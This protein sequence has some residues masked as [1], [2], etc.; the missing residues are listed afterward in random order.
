MNQPP[1]TLPGKPSS[2]MLRTFRPSHF[3]DIEVN[4]GPDPAATMP[5]HFHEEIQITAY[6]GGV[7]DYRIG[8]R[9]LWAT[10]G[11]VVV[12]PSGEPHT[13]HTRE[14]DASTIHLMLVSP[15]RFS[16]AASELGGDVRELEPMAG[17]VPLCWR[18]GELVSAFSVGSPL[19][20]E[21]LFLDLVRDLL[22][23]SSRPI[24]NRAEP[25]AIRLAIEYLRERYAHPVALD[26]LAFQ[27]GLN[28]Y[29]LV[30]AFRKATGVPP[31]S[32]QLQLRVARAKTLLAAGLPATEVAATLG[33]ADQSHFV[34]TFHRFFGISPGRY[35]RSFGVRAPSAPAHLSG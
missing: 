12:I 5:R 11:N 26:E 34:R 22:K 29:Y 30:R 2:E 10:R 14:A 8:A 13:V 16:A 15:A 17:D 27:V 35:Q 18:V 21:T 3:V 24:R 25:F 9:T 6:E 1:V 28:K 4:T 33:F 19:E 31:H 7:R 32:Y 23:V 20:Q